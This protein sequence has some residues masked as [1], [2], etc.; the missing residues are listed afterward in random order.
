MFLYVEKTSLLHCLNPLTKLAVVLIITV[1]VSLSLNPIMP[2]FT[3]LMTL[4]TACLLGG[5]SPREVLK[6]LHIFLFIGLSYMFFML[7]MKGLDNDSRQL[8][9]LMFYWNID[10]FVNIIS[11]GLRIIAFAFMSQIFVLTTRPN[12]LVLSLMI[13]LKLSCV[14]GYAA[15]AA[16]RFL[17]TLQEEVRGIKLAQ[18]IRGIEWEDSLI[19]RLKAP[20]RIMMPLFCSAARRGER[21]AIAMESRGLKADGKRTFYKQTSIGSKDVVFFAVTVLIFAGSALLLSTT[22]LF[23]FSFGFNFS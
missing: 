2:L 20:A 19:S 15:L 8:H 18:E 22:G 3:I 5:F 6:R 14:H 4:A 7:I 16:Y 11:L 13:Q 21:L 17:P 12:D 23:R 10:D 1:I 9:F